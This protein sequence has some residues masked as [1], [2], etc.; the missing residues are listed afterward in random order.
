MY[1]TIFRK[2]VGRRRVYNASELA[3]FYASKTSAEEIESR[4][5]HRFN[6]LWDYARFNCPY[7]TDVARQYR[8]PDALYSLRQL[9]DFP[10]LTKSDI[11][12]NREKIFRLSDGSAITS[13]YATSGST[14]SPA[15]FPKGRADAAERANEVFAYR[16]AQGIVPFDRFVYL[17]GIPGSM[18]QGLAGSVQLYKRKVMDI[19]GNSRRMSAFNLD[20]GQLDASLALIQKFKPRHLIGF[21]S[22]I[23]PLARLANRMQDTYD[24]SFIDTVILS[25]ENFSKAEVVEISSAFS[26][27]VISEYGAEEVGVI[28]ASSRSRL[29]LDVRWNSIAVR[30]ADSS[31]S[32]LITTLGQRAFPLIQYELGDLIEPSCVQNG[33]VLAISS[34]LGRTRESIL[35]RRLNSLPPLPLLPLHLV[36]IMRAFSNIS[37]VQFFQCGE[38]E[39]EIYICMDGNVSLDEVARFFAVKLSELYPDVDKKAIRISSVSNPVMGARE[40]RKVVLGSAHPAVLDSV[41]LPIRTD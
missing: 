28:A 40:K 32:A 17:G 25:S 12:E 37:D 5:L 14:G 22:K 41:S 3:W 26:C 38:G 2:T 20:D 21:P 1:E 11:R 15:K 7:W 35:V 31:G 6:D 34:V 18:T 39:I 23:L 13:Q 30:V 19:V 16:F 36:H 29:C 24:F 10:I 33:S 27:D 4:Q 9:E 8:L